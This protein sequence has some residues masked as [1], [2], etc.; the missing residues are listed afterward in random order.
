LGRVSREN[1]E[2]V[3][4]L[5]ETLLDDESRGLPPR[6]MAERLKEKIEK[7]RKKEGAN[8]TRKLTSGNRRATNSSRT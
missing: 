5:L 1:K 8:H 7:S 6:R 4:I 3:F 2:A